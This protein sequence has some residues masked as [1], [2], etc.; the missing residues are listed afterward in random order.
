MESKRM[1]FCRNDELVYMS[2]CHKLEAEFILFVKPRPVSGSQQLL[3]SATVLKVLYI[4]SFSYRTSE[5]SLNSPFK[6][7]SFDQY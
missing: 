4:E 7:S 2:A 5:F 3:A 6:L 1:E